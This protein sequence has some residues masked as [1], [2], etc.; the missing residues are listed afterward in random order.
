MKNALIFAAIVLIAGCAHT[1]TPAEQAARAEADKQ[2]FLARANAVWS[3]KCESLGFVRP[4]EPWVQC[5]MQL[6]PLNNS[7]P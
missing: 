3:P 1:P 6:L 5:V 7:S 2:A 4:T